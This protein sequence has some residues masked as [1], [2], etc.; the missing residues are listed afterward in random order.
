[1][2]I[3]PLHRLMNALRLASDKCSNEVL[4]VVSTLAKVHGEFD[5]KTIHAAYNDPELVGGGVKNLECRL[6]RRNWFCSNLKQNNGLFECGRLMQDD[7]DG[8]NCPHCGCAIS[9][10]A[11]HVIELKHLYPL[12]LQHSDLLQRIADYYPTSIERLSQPSMDPTARV[13]CVESGFIARRDFERNPSNFKLDIVPR[14]REQAFYLPNSSSA[15]L[16]CQVINALGEDCVRGMYTVRLLGSGK[17]ISVFGKDRWRV[18]KIGGTV[19]I[20]VVAFDDGAEVYKSSSMNYSNN[21][22]T[23]E[24]QNISEKFRRR[25]EFASIVGITSGGG[26]HPNTQEKHAWYEIQRRQLC[27]E[28]AVCPDPVSCFYAGRTVTVHSVTVKRNEYHRTL[29]HPEINKLGRMGCR[30]I[31]SARPFLNGFQ[32]INAGKRA[33]YSSLANIDNITPTTEEESKQMFSKAE[34]LRGTSEW[35]KNA[36]A[37]GVKGMTVEEAGASHHDLPP[38]STRSHWA[39]VDMGSMHYLGIV[40]NILRK[41]V[42]RMASTGA[43]RA[44]SAAP[45]ALRQPPGN[46]PLNSYVSVKDGKVE[47]NGAGEKLHQKKKWRQ[48]LMLYELLPLFPDDTEKHIQMRQFIHTWHLFVTLTAPSEAGFG[49][50]T[51]CKATN[52]AQSLLA[53]YEDLCGKYY[54]TGLKSLS[55]SYIKILSVAESIR[56]HGW[57]DE[58]ATDSRMKPFWGAVGVT[59]GVGAQET[60]EWAMTGF[61][62]SLSLLKV[63][64]T[65]EDEK[66]KKTKAFIQPTMCKEFQFHSEVSSHG[67]TECISILKYMYAGNIGVAI[68]QAFRKSAP[69]WDSVVAGEVRSISLQ[70][71][72]FFDRLRITGQDPEKFFGTYATDTRKITKRGVTKMSSN[73]FVTGVAGT[74][75]SFLMRI[76]ALFCIPILIPTTDGYECVNIPMVAGY[77]YNEVGSS[78]VGYKEYVNPASQPMLFGLTSSVRLHRVTTGFKLHQSADEGHDHSFLNNYI[79]PEVLVALPTSR[80]IPDLFSFDCLHAAKEAKVLIRIDL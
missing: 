25:P 41:F 5:T 73:V 11:D 68:E 64:L 75:S 49:E 26:N 74:A 29:D 69:S 9:A 58:L 77:R 61:L 31:N 40:D 20:N 18:Q 76:M 44:L 27:N 14:L 79:D 51:F 23:E 65:M 48:T 66:K 17:M 38:D 45:Y 12:L 52:A 43:R 36:Q 21:A 30:N 4:A 2:G 3:K 22:R 8:T 24:I 57:T 70:Q 62:R 63:R 6:H 54:P 72:Q 7:F 55:I 15:M 56:K 19:P 78:C 1:M 80:P 34:E 67:Q 13:Y 42:V 32:A 59:G 39:R 37:T 71:L 33:L 16:R 10:F 28:G 47:F 60:E 53:Q 50:D 46:K 35:L